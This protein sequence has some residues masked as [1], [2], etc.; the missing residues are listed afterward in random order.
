MFD[1]VRVS[2]PVFIKT[3]MEKTPVDVILG[4]PG[5]KLLANT[6]GARCLVI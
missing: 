3:S 2:I 1:V 5:L 4:V 6:I